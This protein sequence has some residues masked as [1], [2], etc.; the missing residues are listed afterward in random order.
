MDPQTWYPSKSDSKLSNKGFIIVASNGNDIVVPCLLI[1]VAELKKTAQT[2]HDNITE[3]LDFCRDILDMCPESPYK[4][5]FKF[6]ES[7]LKTA[8]NIASKTVTTTGAADLTSVTSQPVVM[9]VVH[10]LACTLYILIL[11]QKL[12]AVRDKKIL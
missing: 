9:S 2:F 3:G 10:T 8:S 11:Q 6:I 12:K 4:S 1:L 7:S 5:A